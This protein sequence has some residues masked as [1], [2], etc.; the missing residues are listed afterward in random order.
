MALV[1]T[2]KTPQPQAHAQPAF[3]ASARA[4]EADTIL[5][6]GEFNRFVFI[7]KSKF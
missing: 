2:S 7:S 5:I 4:S 1:P 6:K 3:G